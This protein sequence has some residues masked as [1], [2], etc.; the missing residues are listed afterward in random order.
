[1]PNNNQISKEDLQQALEPAELNIVRF[2]PPATVINQ[3]S[4]NTTPTAVINIPEAQRQVAE[5]AAQERAGAL[6]DILVD[7]ITQYASN[8]IARQQLAQ[9][10]SNLEQR[11]QILESTTVTS[12][13]I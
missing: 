3:N 4:Q 1:M 10:L 13:S 8:E 12:G 6:F 2:Q 11:V 9:R 7:M 5:K